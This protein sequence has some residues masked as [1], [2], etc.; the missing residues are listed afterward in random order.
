M[1]NIIVFL[2]ISLVLFLFPTSIHAQWLKYSS[3]PVIS[4]TIQSCDSIH[5]SSPSV[6][7]DQGQYKMWYQGLNNT[8]WSIC[9]ATSIDGINWIKNPTSVITKT[10]YGESGI[11]EVNEPTV[12]KTSSQYQMWFKERINNK[13]RIRYATSTDGILWNILPEIVLNGT[14]NSWD[15]DG[16]TNPY[17]YHDGSQYFLW[18][19][20][21][22]GERWLIG[23]ATSSDGIHWTKNSNNPLNIPYPTGSGFLGGMTMLKIDN[24]YHLWYHVGNNGQNVAIYHA[25]SDSLISQQWTCDQTCEVISRTQNSFD[26]SGIV[27]PDVIM[28][29][30]QLKMWYG[31]YDGS[32][33]YIGLAT[34][35]LP[36]QP[37]PTPTLT[38][39]V[40]IPGFF[41]SWNNEAVLHNQAV[42]QS[43]WKIAPFVKE[44]DGI[45]NTLKNL[46][47]EENKNL[48]IFAYDWRKNID[49][50]IDELKNFLQQKI[51][52]QET[53]THINII[54][55]SFGGIVGR[56]YAQK[57]N[58]LQIDKLITVSSPHQGT[59]QVYKPIEGGE[60]DISNSLL[61]LGQKL[62]VQ[63][64]RNGLKTDKQILS[65]QVPS[66]KDIYPTGQFLIDQNSQPIP[67]TSHIIQ[68]IYLLNY[69]QNI[70]SI[71]PN[72]HTIS[73]QQINT[74]SGWKV[75]NR[76]LLDQ[77]LD[78][79]PDGRPQEQIQESGDGI[80]TLQS[81]QAGN[82]NN[83]FT[84]NH[85]EIIYKKES[86]KKIIEILGISYQD[87][88]IIEGSCTSITPSLI[89]AILSPAQIELSFNNQTI[90]ETDGII[91]VPN[92]S[93]TNYTL[94]VVGK[95]KGKYKVIIGQI[96]NQNDFWTTI[97]GEITQNPPT[98]QID[99][100]P[101]TFSSQLP[102]PPIE[103]LSSFTELIYYLN[104]INK[105]INSLQLKY[106]VDNL[107]QGKSFYQN[108]QK[109]KLKSFLL[110]AQSYLVIA[111][112]KNT[113]LDNK[114]KI[115][116]AMDKLENLYS[117]ALSGYTQGINASRINQSISTY[118]QNASNT[119]TYL[120]AQKNKGKNVISNALLLQLI[121]N[122]LKLAETNLSQ[123][124]LN[125]A[126][127]LL[128]TSGDLL[129]EVKK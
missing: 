121:T 74:L 120:L 43:E 39:V 94:R 116:T 83:Q 41:S 69:N 104:D 25:V 11:Q 26:Q 12:I 98:S 76:T 29:G 95:E 85:G 118:K 30:S 81:S 59:A 105:S 60:L 62:I 86:I 79:Y 77:L 63:L 7:F 102:K 107:K 128:K 14:Q 112:G 96:N 109:A 106:S 103:A 66:L 46:G 88:Q 113:D 33:W 36:V 49:S 23:S 9:Y 31:G 8:G 34:F 27:T 125:Y 50:T 52:N 123:N 15:Y 28:I 13:N 73:G 99:S 32:K 42:N 93:Q 80:I 84:L 64:N 4:P 65:E 90:K 122:K 1:K 82:N 97:N 47:Y 17:V 37:T 67:I 10:S 3:N 129:N 78:L 87:A 45:I 110:L 71:F 75:I 91:F 6:I 5:A 56:I 54:G 117:T 127:I 61:W 2:I 70:N 48:F 119:E 57:Y 44:Y 51:W 40:I 108:N 68:N 35:E 18:Y 115:T 22:N 16:P 53:N 89:F 72:L 92:P 24:K 114:N 55:H 111:W 38:P 19:L 20:A 58:S 101:L 126:E 124:N 21:N 100:Y